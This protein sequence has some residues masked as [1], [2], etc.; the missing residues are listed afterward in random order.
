MEYGERG[1]GVRGLQACW[2]V[3]AEA[4]AA[5]PAQVAPTPRRGTQKGVLT[6]ARV[7][8]PTGESA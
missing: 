3:A 8:Q 1:G 4:R 7:M 6:A 5:Q 2:A